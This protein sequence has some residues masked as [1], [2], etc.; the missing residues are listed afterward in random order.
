MKLWQFQKITDQS[1][2]LQSKWSYLLI[3]NWFRRLLLIFVI[4]REKVIN[5]LIN[6]IQ[7]WWWKN[8]QTIQ[9]DEVCQLTTRFPSSRSQWVRSSNKEPIEIKTI[10]VLAVVMAGG[11][12]SVP[13]PWI[14]SKLVGWIIQNPFCSSWNKTSSCI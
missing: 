5:Q 10:I 14:Q 1:D 11:L 2:W 3:K 12:G 8:Y 9:N 13:F 6:R 7:I 4:T